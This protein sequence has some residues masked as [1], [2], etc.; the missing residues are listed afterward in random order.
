MLSN[1]IFPNWKQ[2]GFN[3]RQS[4]C[5]QD[6]MEAIILLK[7]LS[8][9]VV[10]VTAQDT[11]EKR[12]WAPKNTDPIY[13]KDYSRVNGTP[14]SFIIY[15]ALHCVCKTYFCQMLNRRRRRVAA[16]SLT[17]LWATRRSP[18]P[19]T[20]VRRTTQFYHGQ[21]GLEQLNRW[22]VYRLTFLMILTISSNFS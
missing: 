11:K 7:I 10:S 20:S 19:E 16:T 21:V 12:P 13:T 8:L 14:I 22:C 9:L 3:V 2:Q 1:T 17:T 5:W 18:K 15:C 4:I 6:V